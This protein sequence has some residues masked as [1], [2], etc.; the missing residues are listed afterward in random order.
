MPLP[1]SSST[2]AAGT[3]AGVPAVGAVDAPADTAARIDAALGAAGKIL[4]AYKFGDTAA[5]AEAKAATTEQQ[6]RVVVVGEVKRGKSALVNALVGRRDVS[7]VDVDVTTSAT[8]HLVAATPDHPAGTADLLFPGRTE[9]VPADALPDW[10]TARGRNVCDPGVDS[11]PTRAVI[12][13]DSS[14]LSANDLVVVDTPGT[15]GLDPAHA[16]LA[17]MSAQQAGVL[18]VVCD[19]STPITAPEMEFLSA[20][21]A[22]V[23]SVIVAVTKTDKNLR[24]YQ[25]IV[26]E[27]RRLIAERLQRD[28]P[29]VAVSSIRA[30]AAAELP[31][32]ERRDAALASTG[33]AELRAQIATRLD[34][35]ARL[36]AVNGLRTA[37]EGLRLVAD[38]L[39]TDIAAVTDS[40]AAVADLTA[41]QNR[42]Q[43]LKNH[44]GQWELHLS[45]DLTL[46]RQATLTF[47]DER[48]DEV[49]SK[50]TTRINKNGME[51]LR[52]SPQVFTAEIEADLLA[53]MGATVQNFLDELRT[54]VGPLFDSPVVWA[55]IE[56]Q[57]VTSLRTDPLQTGEVASKRQGL[58]DPTLLT[59][60]MVGTS[61][62]GAL[63]GIGA[64]AGVV[65][66]GVNL[67]YKAM[68]TGKQN[69]LNWLRETLGTARGSTARMLEVAL[70]TARPE[71]VIRYRDHLRTSMEAVQKQIVDAKEAARLD[72]AT[73]EQTL[74]KLTG[75]QRIVAAKTAEIEALIADLTAGAG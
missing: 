40:P 2:A 37:L 71:I 17:S 63:L 51:V 75:N 73:R 23:D 57:I 69:L 65:W 59:M 55:E 26:A 47:L 7:P 34:L 48:L 12:P 6:R 29:V 1:S 15:G 10:V 9:R 44:S 54:I 61:M 16:E 56:Q 18:V 38:R 49:R 19:A 36:P 27:N 43:E 62:L 4:R 58:V 11:L 72:A 33:I 13:V 5:L 28:I 45:R 67:G 50:S 35:G 70:S 42:L 64:I 8:L 68:R 41:E 39:R 53:A 52:R 24:R 66:V 60:G 74:T 46:A 32:G 3:P 14:W 25:P 22:S 30:L 21:S 20:A 31:A